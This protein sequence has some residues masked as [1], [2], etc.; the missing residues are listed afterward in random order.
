MLKYRTR[1]RFGIRTTAEDDDEDDYDSGLRTF[2]FEFDELEYETS[3]ARPQHPRRI[4]ASSGE[5]SRR[6]TSMT[7]FLWE[8]HSW[9]ELRAAAQE[10]DALAKDLRASEKK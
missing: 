8:E 6:R 3:I 9:P 2:E 1:T 10:S 4:A 7:K 5:P